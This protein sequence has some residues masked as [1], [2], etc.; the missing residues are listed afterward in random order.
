[1]VSDELFWNAKLG[2]NLVKYEMHGCF[3]IEFDSGHSL[4]PFH[5]II[6]SHNNMMV[7]PSRSWVTI[8]KVD[9]ALSEG[10]VGDNRMQR[11]RT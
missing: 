4:C 3:I 5:E 1:M 6:N 7:A 9:T 2:D 8:H 11:G 10:T